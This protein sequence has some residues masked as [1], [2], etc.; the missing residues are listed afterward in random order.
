MR[1]TAA[2]RYD[3]SIERFPIKPGQLW[4]CGL[5]RVMAC[6]LYDGCP[7]FLTSA[8]C[9]FVD[10]PYNAALENGFRTKAGLERNP[11]GFPRFL[12][13][14]FGRIDKI[15][16]RTC[17]VEIGKQHVNDISARLEARFPHVE[18][19]AAT[20]YKRSPCHVAR[21]GV[22]PS[23]VHYAG[24]DEQDIIT[25]ICQHEPFDMIADP[26]MGRGSVGLAAYKASRPFC[27]AELNPA[28][29][30]VLVNRIHELG[31]EWR[32]DGVRF[33]PSPAGTVP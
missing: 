18:I 15:A 29:L 10:P 32:V 14:L 27:G 5:G 2:W 4:E 3:G 22:E 12:D 24:L 21:G 33:E 20:Y 9:V 16:P 30:A 17:F 28:R 13:A 7:D 25:L 1:M 6:D 26:C 11:N 19:Y 31:G 8:D 23:E